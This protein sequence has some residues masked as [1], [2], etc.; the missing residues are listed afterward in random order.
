[1]VK[2][3]V[4][5][6]NQ[7]NKSG[8]CNNSLRK[9]ICVM[10][11]QFYHEDY[12]EMANSGYCSRHKQCK[13]NTLVNWYIFVCFVESR[14]Q[15]VI[16]GWPQT[17]GNSPASA[18]QVLGLLAFASTLVGSKALFKHR[19]SYGTTNKFKVQTKRCE[20]CYILGSSCQHT[21]S[22]HS[23][24]WVYGNVLSIRGSQKEFIR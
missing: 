10:Y 15:Q 13:T 7:E 4:S 2:I 9:E 18:L 14:S 5:L 8:W 11:F 23:E 22:G 3:R 16:S 21:L 20:E 6:F 1:M 17:C 24:W 12:S 19:S